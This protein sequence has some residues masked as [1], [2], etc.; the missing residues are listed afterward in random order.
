MDNLEEEI[1]GQ[2]RKV[3]NDLCLDAGKSLKLESNS[4]L[5]HYFRITLKVGDASCLLT[6]RV[7]VC[8]GGGDKEIE[9]R[10]GQAR[11]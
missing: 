3:A 8:V 1:Q 2:M 6:V 10:L 9:Y 4:Q 7:C 5:G 11:R